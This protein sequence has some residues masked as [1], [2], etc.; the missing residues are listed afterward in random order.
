MMKKNKVVHIPDDVHARALEYC[1]KHG[2]TMCEWV[3]GL[4]EKAASAP[5]KSALN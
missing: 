5:D 1:K 2:I 4:I 3:S